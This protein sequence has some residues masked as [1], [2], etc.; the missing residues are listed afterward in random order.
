MD[1]HTSADLYP[2]ISE[3]DLLELPIPVTDPTASDEIV[4]AIRHANA[5]RS[6]D[7]AKLSWSPLALN[8]IC[9][10]PKLLKAP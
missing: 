4:D 1:L 6:L 8:P 7:T 2:V 9:V 10:A 3:S 5:A